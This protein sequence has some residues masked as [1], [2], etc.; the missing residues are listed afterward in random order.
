MATIYD[1]AKRAGV[2]RST[3]SRVLNN[4]PGVHPETR[5]RVLAAVRELNYHPNFAARALKRQ[6][7][8]AV[9]VII[10]S[11]FREPRSDEP[12]G[13]YFT[14]IIRGA[15][16]YFTEHRMA[17][18]LL[19][20]EGTFEFYQSIFERRQVDGILFIDLELGSDMT[21]RL[22]S[23]GF[24]FV[25]IGNA[26]EPDVVGV[27][28][29]NYGS[30][31]RVVQYLY[32]QGHRRIAIIN[33]PERRLAS[34]DRRA[35]FLAAIEHLGLDFPEAYDQPGD[36]SE[37]SGQKA[38]R[39]LLQVS[40][41]PTAV[42]AINDR[43]AIGAIRAA[44]DAGL[45]VPDDISVVGFDDIPV[46]PYINPPLTTMRQPLYELG[47]E[48]ARLL[49]EIIANGAASV[50]RVVLP[51]TLIERNTVALRTES[52]ERG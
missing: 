19:D 47:A 44:R 37:R 27:D 12:R 33:G 40:P 9:G 41:R 25:V 10:P 49:H 23:L 8:D 43:M 52:P 39:R 1:V 26:S 24:P 29:D 2:S 22:K 14:E 11:S 3:V 50:S 16:N 17:V 30:S 13:Y 7:A 31:Q 4:Q 48:A 35:G 36:F 6:R 38:M 5:E 15:Y 18:T 42:Y 28:V 34:R 45:N 51:A 20:D 21:R 32:S 46:A